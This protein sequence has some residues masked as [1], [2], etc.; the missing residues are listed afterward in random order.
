MKTGETWFEIEESGLD[1]GLIVDSLEDRDKLGDLAMEILALLKD[2]SMDDASIAQFAKIK[3]K[4]ESDE[5]E[6]TLGFSM[7]LAEDL[8]ERDVN[9]VEVLEALERKP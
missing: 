9:G 5:G 1:I 2:L 8:L 6:L 3:L 7:A 4:F